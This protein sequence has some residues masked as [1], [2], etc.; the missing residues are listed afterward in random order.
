VRSVNAHN[1]GFM[2]HL[3][4]M[5]PGFQYGRGLGRAVSRHSKEPTYELTSAHL[6]DKIRSNSIFGDVLSQE[7][8]T[9]SRL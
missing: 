9:A 1:D 7:T 8:V 2:W 4:H 6:A 5:S 3:A